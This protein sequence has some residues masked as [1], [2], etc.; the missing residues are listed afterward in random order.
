M[1]DEIVVCT[2]LYLRSIFNLL[3]LLSV[4]KVPKK[5]MMNERRNKMRKERMKERMKETM[6]EMD[7]CA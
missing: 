4:P 3:H 6:K 5:E 7:H 1:N 2:L